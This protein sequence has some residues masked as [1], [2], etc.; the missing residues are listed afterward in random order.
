MTTNAHQIIL[1]IDSSDT[2]L[3]I[4]VTGPDGKTA[5]ASSSHNTQE[6][7]VVALATR[8]LAKSG[9]KLAD[10]NRVFVLRGPGRF[11]GIR[12]GLTVAS[13]LSELNGAQ[14]TAAT[15]PEALAEETAQTPQFAQWL[16]KNPSG[17]LA[18]IT[19]A[20]R[21]EFFCQLFEISKGKPRPAQEPRWLS[22]VEMK[23]YLAEQKKP[24]YCAGWAANRSTLAPWLPGN[25][26]AAPPTAKG[27]QPKTLI[28]MARTARTLK[29]PPAPLYL[30][31]ARYELEAARKKLRVYP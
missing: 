1:A 13:L 23:T 11:T 31:P 28:A 30:K 22:A 20:F 6:N 3:K 19:Y 15:V 16:E 4:A 26:L 21:E 25:C 7:H 10:V 18:A 8:L 24:I 12:I 14:V 2:P 27:I 17:L 9:K 29:A 5:S